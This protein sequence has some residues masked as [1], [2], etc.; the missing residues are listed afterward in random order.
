MEESSNL[1]HVDASLEHFRSLAK[2]QEHLFGDYVA[3]CCFIPN[4]HLLTQHVYEIAQAL[5]ERLRQRAVQSQKEGSAGTDAHGRGA[6]QTLPGTRAISGRDP[7]STPQAASS[8]GHAHKP[9]SAG[10]EPRRGG[11][12]TLQVAVTRGSMSNSLPA[13]APGRH[14]SIAP[15][16]A[17][18]PAGIQALPGQVQFHRML[19]AANAARIPAK[20]A[21]QR[22][23]D[24][25]EGEI[26]TYVDEYKYQLNVPDAAVCLQTAWRARSVRVFFNR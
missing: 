2:V 18:Q 13:G 21:F 23:L 1:A 7:G 8:L 19:A 14:S 20:T 16:S 10:R 5:D 4:C 12:T 9:T 17:T 15:A 6:S 22:E 25:I 26:D 11:H 24:E 3:A